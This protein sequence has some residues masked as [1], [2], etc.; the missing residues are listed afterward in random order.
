MQLIL[1]TQQIPWITA[2][3]S[4]E[5]V[6]DEFKSE[7][8]EESTEQAPRS[9]IQH[10]DTEDG[11]DCDHRQKLHIRKGSH[12][13]TYDRLHQQRGGMTTIAG[14]RV[15]HLGSIHE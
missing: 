3:A 4:E 10:P 14:C 11:H 2:D 5:C 12:Q 15:F 1:H 6:G 13:T 9:I 8:D 7:Q